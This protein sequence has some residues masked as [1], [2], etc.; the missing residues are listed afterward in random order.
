MLTTRGDATERAARVI[1]ESQHTS[2][3][4]RVFR[5]ETPDRMPHAE[6]RWYSSQ[7][8]APPIS[9]KILVAEKLRAASTSK[10]CAV[11]NQASDPTTMAQ[12][13]NRTLFRS[14]PIFSVTVRSCSLE[15]SEV[16]SL[17]SRM[18]SSLFVH[19]P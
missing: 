11:P 7:V 16:L 1:S 15:G 4:T 2:E 10:T 3:A 6:E 18:T 9:R 8:S 17:R 13:P 5:E 14:W 19:S 12:A